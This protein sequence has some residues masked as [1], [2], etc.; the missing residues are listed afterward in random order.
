MKV[1]LIDSLH[2]FPFYYHMME[3]MPIFGVKIISAY[4]GLLDKMMEI[5]E[6][7]M[8]PVSTALYSRMQ[9]DL[10][11]VPD[12]CLNSEGYTRSIVM[13]S[14]VPVEELHGKRI[15]LSSASET[16]SVVLK[17]ILNNFYD[18]NPK[19]IKVDSNPLLYHLDAALISGNEALIQNKELIKYSYDIGDLWKRKTGYPVVF[20]LF[21]IQKEFIKKDREILNRIIGSYEESLKEL[22]NSE[23]KIYQNAVERYPGFNY[24][25]FNFYNTIS[26]DLTDELKEALMFFYNEAHSLELIDNKIDAIKFL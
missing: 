14:K 22:G 10:L 8:S 23:S 4:E 3:R 20:S 19:Y 17:I 2:C 9:N 1:G 13:I 24:N 21:A 6:L 16:P 5:K 25:I 12:Y 7:D 15:G 26:Y 11:V 18:I